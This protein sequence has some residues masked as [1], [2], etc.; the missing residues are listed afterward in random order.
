MA[1]QEYLEIDNQKFISALAYDGSNNLIYSGKALT[2]SSKA[3]ACWQIKKYTYDGSSN[4][5]DIQFCDGNNNFDNVWN[6]RVS[7]SYS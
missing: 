1:W 7:Y 6:D 5:T 4:L 3:T 2:G